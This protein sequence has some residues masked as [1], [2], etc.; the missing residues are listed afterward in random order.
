MSWIVAILLAGGKGDR[1]GDALPKQFHLLS[2]KKLYL[3]TLETFL[4]ILEIQ[5]VLIVSHPEWM[6]TIQED[7]KIFSQKPVSQKIIRLVSGGETRQHSSF[8]GLQACSAKTSHVII[9]DAVRP[10]VTPAII[11]ENIALARQY[12]ACDTCIPSHDTLVH[13]L[14]RQD[15]FTIPLRHEYLRGQTPQSFSYPLILR[16]HQVALA[17]GVFDA[18]DDCQLVLRLPHQIK[19]AQGHE[20]NIKIT[21]QLDLVLAEQLLRLKTIPFIKTS[22][23]SLQGKVFVVTG[24]TGGIG[25]EITKHLIQEGATV[26]PLARS[27]SYAI[28]LTSENA[29]KE[30]F[31]N[32]SLRY[33]AIDGLINAVGYLKVDPLKELSSLE[34]EKMIHTNFTSVVYACKYSHIKPSGHILNLASSSYT[35]GRASYA[36]YSGMKAAIVNFTQGLALEYPHLNVNSLVPPRT[37]TPMRRQNFPEE[38]P[39][40]LLSPKIVAEEIVHILHAKQMTGM[41]IEIKK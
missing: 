34:I 8:L 20:E 38:N 33:G 4:K 7:L 30:V 27:S 5:E 29:V 40:L 26:I 15:I 9:H 32:I 1:F 10:F 23:T 18:T 25:Q 31:K 35:R 41:T 22:H 11:Q 21:T 39:S 37:D 24:A 12:G 19:I 3:Y 28:D 13:T 6:E 16:A 2:G 36:I 17:E 14:N